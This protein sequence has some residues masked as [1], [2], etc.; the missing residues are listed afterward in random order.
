M[1]S[2]RCSL[3]SCSYYWYFL[4]TDTIVCPPSILSQATMFSVIQVAAENY[5]HI[6]DYTFTSNYID[7]KDLSW[8]RGYVHDL[9][10]P[11]KLCSC[12]W[13]PPP[14]REHGMSTIYPAIYKHDVSDV[15]CYL[16]LCWCHSSLLPSVIM[17]KFIVHDSS[18]D[19]MDFY[20]LC[21]HYKLCWSLWPILL[22][23]LVQSYVFFHRRPVWCCY[24]TFTLKLGWRQW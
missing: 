6:N 3:N 13:F 11:R 5:I 14:A 24:L 7:V 22:P 18:K 8:R 15:C 17:L 10:C 12:L 9:T 16:I 2:L 21:S 1:H 19:L 20:S 23:E 4:I